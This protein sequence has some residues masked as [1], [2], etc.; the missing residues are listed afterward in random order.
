MCDAVSSTGSWDLLGATIVPFCIRSS[1]VAMG[2]YPGDDSM[3]Y[4]STME[5]DFDGVNLSRLLPLS[6]ASSVL[7][8]MLGDTLKRRR[9]ILSMG[10]L[11][12][13]EGA[14]DLDG[15]RI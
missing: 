12:S 13:Q 7:A 10:L 8:S 6:K 1:A 11:T 3:L 9:T 14:A 15:C 5:A 4:H 2:L